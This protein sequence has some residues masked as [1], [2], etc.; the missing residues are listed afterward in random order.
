MSINTRVSQLDE[1]QLELSPSAFLPPYCMGKCVLGAYR[2]PLH[3]VYLLCRLH[4]ASYLRNQR[5]RSFSFTTLLCV[6]LVSQVTRT[7]LASHRWIFSLSCQMILAAGA[8]VAYSQLWKYGQLNQE[9]Y[10]S[11][12]GKWKVRSREEEERVKGREDT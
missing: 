3:S 7:S 11:W 12:L 8:E 9:K 6:P 5:H 1:S 4:P 2:C 10:T